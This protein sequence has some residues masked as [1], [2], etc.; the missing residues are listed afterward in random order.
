MSTENA[1]HFINVR[2]LNV[3][4]T[5]GGAGIGRVIAEKLCAG[6]ARVH[7][8]DISEEAIAQAVAAGIPGLTGSRS[9]ASDPKDADRLLEE[10]EEK[11]GGLDM[12]VNNVGIAG[13]TGGIETYA[14]AD[15]EESIDVNLTSHFY[16]LKRFVPLL[17]NSSRNPSI[18]AMSS[19]GGR[20]GYGLRTPYAAAKWGIIGMVK[21][22]AVEL[23]P[24]DIRAN[25]ILPGITAG[26]RLDRVIA[27]RAEATGVT[28]EEMRESYVSKVSMRRAVQP[29]DI[30][31]LAVFLASDLARNIS[32]QAISVD[33]NIEYLSDR[34]QSGRGTVRAR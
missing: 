18:L 32:G 14:D 20:L 24:V 8:T 26:P 21:S 25:A 16:M 28:F 4:I 11:L 5:A 7:V 6:G 9:D 31:N 12:L 10:V 13:P 2:D 34:H 1:S 22:L 29:E 3:L 15:V 17:K 33:G 19:I 23:G 27:A 30:A